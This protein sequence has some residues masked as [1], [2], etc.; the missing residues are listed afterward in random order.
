MALKL[1]N[2]KWVELISERIGEVDSNTDDSRFF[3]ESILSFEKFGIATN[4]LIENEL[5]YLDCQEE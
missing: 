5:E 1:F 2:S 4:S 3:Y